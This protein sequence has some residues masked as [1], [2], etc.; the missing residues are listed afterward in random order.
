MPRISSDEIR[1]A[2]ALLK[3]EKVFTLNRLVSILR[4]SSRT[5]QTKLQQWRIYTSYNKNSKYYT[6]PD[7]PQFNSYGLWRYEGKYFSKHGNLKKTVVHL[8]CKSEYGLSGDQIGKLVGLLPR[9]FLHHFRE[10]P[11]IRREKR[12]GVYVYY[13]A[14]PEQYQQQVQN[15]ISAVTYLDKPLTD[16]DAIIILAALIKHH[17][18]TVEDILALPEIK[19]REFPPEIIRQFLDE[20]SLLKKNPA[21]K[22]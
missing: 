18:I 20:H 7:I 6:M 3:K 9:S 11:G 4:C 19:A 21:T 8:V 15:R 5:A 10:V 2:Q 1:K 17:G 16:A 12:G 14:A 13:S 22:R